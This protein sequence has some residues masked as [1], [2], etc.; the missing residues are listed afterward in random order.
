[1]VDRMVQWLALGATG[2]QR[3]FETSE[4][5]KNVFSLFLVIKFQKKN[6]FLEIFSLEKRKKFFYRFLEFQK[7]WNI[8]KN[9]VDS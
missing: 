9:I 4:F 2:A 1:M 7:N 5:K 3:F 8:R 6:I